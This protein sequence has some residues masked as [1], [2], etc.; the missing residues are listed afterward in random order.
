MIQ[1][2]KTALDYATVA[3]KPYLSGLMLLDAS[4]S[5]D[6]TAVTALLADNTD[7][8]FAD[9]VGQRCGYVM[10]NMCNV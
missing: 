1:D 6:K 10:C 2:G 8:D 7:K 4:G 5:G 3:V 9:E